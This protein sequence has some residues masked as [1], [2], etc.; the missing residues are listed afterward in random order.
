MRRLDEALLRR[1]A[2]ELLEEMAAERD[3]L[4]GE[5]WTQQASRRVELIDEVEDRVWAAL[6]PEKTYG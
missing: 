5:P 2:M 4:L 1:R 6:Q 3:R